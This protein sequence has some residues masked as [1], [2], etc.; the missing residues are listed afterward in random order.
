VAGAFL[1]FGFIL[2]AIGGGN[3]HLDYLDEQ[4][5]RLAL[6]FC[7]LVGGCKPQLRILLHGA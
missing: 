2:A 7:V 3:A 4:Y 5:A 6:F 1:Q